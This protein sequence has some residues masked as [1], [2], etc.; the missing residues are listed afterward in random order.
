MELIILAGIGLALVALLYGVWGALKVLVIDRND[1]ADF[2]RQRADEPIKKDAIRVVALG[3]STFQALGASRPELGTVGRIVSYL[4]EK[5]G[6]PVHIQNLSVSGGRAADVANSQLPQADLD[7]AD[8][9]VVAVGAND[10]FKSTDLTEFERSIE[11]LASALPADKTILADV[12]LVKQREDY[13][14][15]IGR[16]R[17]KHGI[18]GANLKDGFS[19]AKQSWRLTARDF[20]HPSDYGYEFWFAAFQPALDELIAEQNSIQR[21]SPNLSG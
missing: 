20:F 15:I 12:A 2:W 21:K 14:R 1:Y 4:E 10:T 5:T 19:D 8:I 16:V 13:Q 3:D 17:A 6:R 18:T 9:V 11:K 7:G